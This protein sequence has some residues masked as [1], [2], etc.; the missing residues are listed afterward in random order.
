MICLNSKVYHCWGG[1]NKKG[2]SYTMTL[3]KGAQ[4][5]RN[6][7]LKQYFLNVLNTQ[8]KHE[9]ENTGFVKD[10]QGTIKSYKQK[11]T[12]RSYFYAKHKVLA[13]SVRQLI[14]IYVKVSMFAYLPLF[15]I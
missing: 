11:K 12:G 7:L 14:S 6:K 4:Q 3:C 10:V 1:N 13:D 15:R 2:K 5:K 8:E 9:V